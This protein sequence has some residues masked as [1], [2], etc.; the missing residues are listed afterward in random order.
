MTAG[1]GELAADVGQERAMG[2][3]DTLRAAEAQERQE[4]REERAALR[5][6]YSSQHR[7]LAGWGIDPRSRHFYG[8]ADALQRLEAEYGRDRA[9]EF[10]APVARMMAAAEGSGADLA[11]MA[12]QAGFTS[13]GEWFG[14]KV[15]EG[16]MGKYGM[17]GVPLFSIG[18]GLR[19]PAD[20]SP[21]ILT[22]YDLS[23]GLEIA[24]ALG[25]TAHP[26]QVRAY[27]EL[28]HA[29]RS[30]AARAGAEGVD[31]LVEAARSISGQ[32]VGQPGWKRWE[33][34]ADAAE[35]MAQQYGVRIAGPAATELGHLRSFRP[36]AEFLLE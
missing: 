27:A 1:V 15:E 17:G 8:L 31:A 35:R 29:F 3:R 7:D 30:P 33:P 10:A 36:P 16:V 26:D 14:W 9:R 23:R 6:R 11:A 25:R 21:G 24:E 5:D 2:Q 19:Y 20:W 32:F 4:Q 13:P 18:E 28:V 12:R 34:F 22:A